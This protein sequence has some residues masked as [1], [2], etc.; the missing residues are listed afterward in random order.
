MVNRLLF[1]CLLPLV[2]STSAFAQEAPA[3][4]CDTYAASDF[5]PQP[6]ATAVPFAKVNPALAVPACEAAVRQYPNSARLTYQLGRA[7]EMG[8]NF[9]PAV[10]QYRKAAAQNYAPA[11][12]KL[13]VMYGD[14]AGVPKDDQQ[15][16]AWYRKAADQGDAQAQSNLG[17]M[18]ADG[19]G[20]PRNDQ[21]A[22]AWYRKAAAQNYALAQYNLGVMYLNGR[23]VPQDD[24][25]AFSWFRKAADQGYAQAQ[26]N[27]RAL[28][29]KLLAQKLE[30]ERALAQKLE[31]EAERAQDDGQRIAAACAADAARFCQV[32]APTAADF[33]RGGIVYNCLQRYFSGGQLSRQ[34]FDAIMSR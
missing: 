13:G 4:D 1:L 10:E 12:F 31:A 23:G 21:E 22:V 9:T 14:G 26:S 32:P 8:N 11:Q 3:T 28:A 18:Y 5:E 27:L 6:K 15:A 34:C 33:Q 7:Y 16:V 19:A 2:L 30:A 20:V 25:Q 17:A 29:Q 24:Q